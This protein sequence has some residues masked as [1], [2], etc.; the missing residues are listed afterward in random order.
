MG[1]NAVRGHA[2]AKEQLRTAYERGR[3]AHAFLFAGPTGVGKRTFATEFAKALLCENPP[4]GFD[5]CDRCPACR[6]VAAGTHPQFYVAKTPEDKQELPVEVTREFRSRL[7]LRP[8][9]GG[10]SVGLVEDADDFN[11]SSANCLLKTLEEPPAGAVLVLLATD[12]ARQLPTVRSRCQVVPFHPLGD[13]DVAAV[14]AE[15]G[16]TES[17]EIARLV[18]LSGGSPGLAV[19]LAGGALAAFRDTLLAAL[20]APRPDPVSLAQ[21]WIAVCEEAGKES[22]AQRARASNSL[23]IALDVLRL[24]LRTALDPANTSGDDAAAVRAIASRGGPDGGA[25]WIEACTEADYLVGRKVQLALVVEKL[26]GQL[27]SLPA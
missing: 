2:A 26:A 14:L 6:Q 17:A 4:A 25:G 11:E 16:V 22:A 20:A 18:R 21:D 13:A 27:C 3:L 9:R 24:A 8:A 1:F 15:H 5:A 7:A 10:R 19:D 23:R 12:L